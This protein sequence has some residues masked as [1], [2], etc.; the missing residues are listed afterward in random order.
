MPTRDD[1]DVFVYTPLAYILAKLAGVPWQAVVT[2]V[3]IVVVTTLVVVFSK[4]MATR[5]RANQKQENERW[6][7]PVL[8]SPVAVPEPKGHLFDTHTFS[9]EQFGKNFLARLNKFER[10]AFARRFS[11]VVASR[12]KKDLG[13]EGVQEKPNHQSRTGVIVRFSDKS[14]VTFRIDRAA[15]HLKITGEDATRE[16]IAAQ[17]QVVVAVLKVMTAPSYT[18]AFTFDDADVNDRLMESFQDQEVTERFG[19]EVAARI[20]KEVKV[21]GGFEKASP[22]QGGVKVRFSDESW[23]DFRINRAASKFELYIIG[24]ETT[25]EWHN[26]QAAAVKDVLEEMHAA[27]TSQKQDV[28]SVAQIPGPVAVIIALWVGVPWQAVATVVVVVGAVVGLVALRNV[29]KKAVAWTVRTSVDAVK[30][31]VA[32]TER[33]IDNAVKSVLLVREMR[34]LAPIVRSPASSNLF[35]NRLAAAVPVERSVLPKAPDTRAARLNGAFAAVRGI[36]SRPKQLVATAFLAAYLTAVQVAGA[37]VPQTVDAISN[38]R[39][40]QVNVSVV[41]VGELGDE[42]STEVDIRNVQDRLA[43]ATEDRT[44]GYEHDVVVALHGTL[45]PETMDQLAKLE[46]DNPGVMRIEAVVETDKVDGLYSYNK[47]L[48]RAFLNSGYKLKAVQFALAGNYDSAG[49]YTYSRVPQAFR[50]TGALALIWLSF[51][52][53]GAGWVQMQTVEVMTGAAKLADIGA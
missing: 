17:A 50:A 41:N 52:D 48:D 18:K 44:N 28:R 3:V 38:D 23:I 37:R 30:S 22:T 35:V 31:T 5:R 51:A 9:L 36:A 12:L 16:K 1:G 34:T 8:K 13:A 53:M 14:Y 27:A 45:S 33:K 25:D 19:R 24:E 32:W 49:F 26:A 42:E 4:R 40:S 15:G 7:R 29:L 47:V 20:G 21:E 11:K 43:K 6:T 46:A 39:Q 2:I 10:N